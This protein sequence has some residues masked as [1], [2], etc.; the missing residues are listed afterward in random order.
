MKFIRLS[1]FG[2]SF[3]LCLLALFFFSEQPLDSAE[4]E[5][6]NVLKAQEL[7]D[8]AEER[9]QAT[10]FAEAIERYR[11][12][13]EAIETQGEHLEL[14]GP[15]CCRLGQAFF[16]LDDYESAYAYFERAELNFKAE[17]PFQEQATYLF[18]LTCRHLK[19]HSQAIKILR[20]N[21]YPH[22]FEEVQF[23]LALNTFLMNDLPSAKEQF[24]T[25]LGNSSKPRLSLLGQLYL[26]R[27]CLADG[28]YQN[29]ALRLESLQKQIPDSD[30]LSLEI[31]YLQGEAAFHMQSYAAAINHFEKALPRRNF[32]RAVWLNET[33]YYLGWAHLKIADDRHP[34]EQRQHFERAES[35]FRRL[36]DNIPEERVYLALAHCYLVK[37]ERLKDADAYVQAGEILSRADRFTTLEAKTHA[38]LLRAEAASSVKLFGDDL[39]NS[40]DTTLLFSQAAEAFGEAFQL[41]KGEDKGRAALALKA[42]VQAYQ[43]CNS[44]ESLEKAFNLLSTY[45]DLHHQD[46]TALEEPQEFYYLH[47]MIAFRLAEELVDNNAFATAVERILLQAL[48]DYPKGRFSDAC[49]K[50]LATFYLRNERY[51]QAEATFLSIVET[52]P[53]ST[54]AGDALHWGAYC[55]DKLGREEA[56][57][58]TCKKQLF[59]SYSD[60]PFAA[61]AYFTYY[62]YRHYLQGDRAAIKHL[63]AFKGKFPNSPLQITAHYLMGLDYKRERKSAE[64]RSIR[65]KNLFKAINHFFKAEAQFDEL[66]KQHLIDEDQ[67]VHFAMIHYRALLERALSNQAVADDSQAAKRAIYLQYAQELLVQVN[68]EMIDANHP[69][70]SYLTKAQPFPKIQ[71]ESLYFLV[72]S[73]I[74]CGNIKAAHRVIKQILAKYASLGISKSYY[75][76]CIYYE[77]G[78]AAMRQADYE[79]AL[80]S[81]LQ[82][83]QSDQGCF[84]S[85]N[86]KLDLWIQQSMCYKALYQ[87]DH[88]ML[89]LSKVINDNTVSSLRV[90]AMFLRAEVYALQGRHELARKQLEATAKKGGEWAIKAKIKLDEEYGTQ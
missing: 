12:L 39:K 16:F 34:D 38:L 25:L 67:L 19:K 5:A 79:S 54:L 88:A 37:G 11:E 87:T 43:R 18:A 70:A 76:S 65:K 32:E 15:I 40:A 31:A 35:H 44:K 7:F 62:S 14:A 59:E 47:A 29:A 57:I 21:S 30:Q 83:E 17:V 60:S 68:R 46:L 4:Q 56:L 42:Q 36:L 13:L 48:T 63:Q 50:L 3:W 6:P 51:P 10:L 23:E 80:Q 86:Q 58:Q 74:K 66:Y 61:S 84:L 89:I 9:Y 77:Q 81:L 2:T 82:A 85:V 73:Y 41:L 26:S 22:T 52:Y 53:H 75:L 20:Q 71:Q 28:D 33:L 69:I 90:K 64:G 8:A 24:L 49:L 27:I 72:Q 45:L 55:S 78:M 1:L